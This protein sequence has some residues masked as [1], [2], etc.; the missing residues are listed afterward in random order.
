M[1]FFLEQGVLEVKKKC[2]DNVMVG[3]GTM[4][5]WYHTVQYVSY[6]KQQHTVV[7]YIA[8]WR[9]LNVD[10]LL[11]LVPLQNEKCVV[12][13]RPLLDTASAG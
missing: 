2:Y 8:Y 6:R 7:S 12:K 9:G 10:F 5:V 11:F 3:R 13:A 4:W 1:C